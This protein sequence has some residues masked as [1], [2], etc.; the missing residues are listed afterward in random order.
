M[1]TEA[2]ATNKE[3]QNTLEYSCKM[4]QYF[5]EKDMSK[6][7][8]HPTVMKP[9]RKAP[10]RREHGSD[11]PA[12]VTLREEGPTHRTNAEDQEME[13]EEMQPVST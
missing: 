10:L 2:Q 7:D 1:A 12:P 6:K 4:D 13:E 3:P 5:A 11:R 8:K 9:I